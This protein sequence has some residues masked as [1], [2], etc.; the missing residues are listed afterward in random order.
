MAA[1]NVLSV[2]EGDPSLRAV[3][4]AGRRIGELAPDS[5]LGIR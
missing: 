3:T 4:A 5:P 2:L 1:F